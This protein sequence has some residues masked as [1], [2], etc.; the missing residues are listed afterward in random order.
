MPQRLHETPA[1]GTDSDAFSA[2]KSARTWRSPKGV[3]AGLVGHGSS[4]GSGVDFYQRQFP[5]VTSDVRLS[6]RPNL[7]FAEPR[8]RI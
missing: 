3:A 7:F 8:L 5:S 6:I 4:C 2:A 1:A